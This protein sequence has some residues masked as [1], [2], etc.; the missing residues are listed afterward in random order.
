MHTPLRYKVVKISGNRVSSPVPLD[1][2]RPRNQKS[3]VPETFQWLSWREPK[4]MH[5]YWHHWQIHLGMGLTVMASK[6]LPSG[7]SNEKTDVMLL[8]MIYC[9]TTWCVFLCYFFGIWL[10]ALFKWI[11]HFT[12]ILW[13][14]R[15]ADLCQMA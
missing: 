10:I 3:Q 8:S 14:N 2:T 5:K 15:F 12:A 4:C 13:V 9:N 11:C 7:C 6:E 1:L